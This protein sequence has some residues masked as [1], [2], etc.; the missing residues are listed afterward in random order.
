[1]GLRPYESSVKYYVY[2]FIH[3]CDDL[4][5]LLSVTCIMTC[6]SLVFGLGDY[7]LSAW[8][9]NLSIYLFF[10]QVR[11]FLATMGMLLLC[12]C[13]RDRKM[14]YFISFMES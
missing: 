7:P 12:T 6:N 5:Y 8:L 14:F 9:L 13:L 2:I 1:M 3:S 11:K 4:Q 10:S